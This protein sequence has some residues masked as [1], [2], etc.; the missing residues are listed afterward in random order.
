M[1]GAPEKALGRIDIEVKNE[2][3]ILDGQVPGLTS[4]RLAGAIAWWVPGVRDVINGIAVEPPEEDSADM[5]A[6]AV[7]LV[8][9]K[10][11]FVKAIQIRVGA[12]GTQVRLAGRVPNETEREAAD[13]DAWCIF[14]V[15][16][17]V[18]EIEDCA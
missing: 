12:Q 7:R 15:D 6:K 10:D 13:R 4:K 5:I 18:N 9:E 2:V 17:V 8:L 3:V 11:P 1:R 14:G 16:N